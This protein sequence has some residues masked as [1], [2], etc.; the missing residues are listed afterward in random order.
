MLFF[1]FAP[2]TSVLAILTAVL[3]AS[4]LQAIS[5]ACVPVYFVSLALFIWRSRKTKSIPG[6]CSV[7]GYDLRGTP[8]R[9]PECGTL[10]ETVPPTNT[11]ISN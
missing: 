7:C 1:L 10:T 9:C 4:G 11:G 6:L 5:V 3:A 2:I 8:E